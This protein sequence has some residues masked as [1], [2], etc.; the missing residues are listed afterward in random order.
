MINVM[1]VDDEFYVLEGI[2]KLFI[3]NFP[4]INCRS[5]SSALE[6][7]DVLDDFTPDLII[8][9]IMMGQMSGLEFIKEIR[10]MEINPKIAI[11]SGYDEFEFAKTAIKLK[12]ENYFLKP[13]N[14]NEMLIFIRRMLKEIEETRDCILE[15]EMTINEAKRIAIND[16][17][18]FGYKPLD[19]QNRIERL[20]M[21]EFFD[22]YQVGILQLKDFFIVAN[23]KNSLEFKELHANLLGLIKNTLSLDHIISETSPGEFVFLLKPNIDYIPIFKIIIKIMKTDYGIIGRFA[24][25]PE[26]KKFQ[27]FYDR[28]QQTKRI[29]SEKEN[30]KFCNWT[31]Q[32]FLD[33]TSIAIQQQLDSAAYKDI[34]QSVEDLLSFVNFGYRADK[35]ALVFLQE[36]NDSICQKIGFKDNIIQTRIDSFTEVLPFLKNL[37]EKLE[38][39]VKDTTELKL[40][41]TI[42]DIQNYILENYQQATLMNVADQ[43]DISYVYLSIVFKERTGKSFKDFLTQTKM[44]KAKE[45]LLETDK[46][47]YEIA[48]EVGYFDTKYFSH[49]FE[50]YWGKL[51]TTLRKEHNIE[52]YQ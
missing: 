20:H 42:S 15:N 39:Q 22:D 19:L 51:P 2:K 21:N 30:L 10:E 35:T 37:M 40:K 49:K 50:K 1:L 5:F 24:I 11:I 28:Y 31:L 13:I 9:D 14:Q 7:L 17:I 25:S 27:D 29:I 32:S 12:V 8:S 36:T 6:A 41:Q 4:Q 52:N 45:L 44:N 23:F 26:A 38:S 48:S 33:K 46:K 3:D 18:M 16:L 34:G 43:F 47:I